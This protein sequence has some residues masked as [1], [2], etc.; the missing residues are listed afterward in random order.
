MFKLGKKKKIFRQG[1]CN[2]FLFQCCG[3]DWIMKQVVPLILGF[4]TEIWRM[5]KLQ[6]TSF[7]GFVKQVKVG[8]T[9][10]TQST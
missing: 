9:R 2:A 5:K 3:G 10:N 6:P 4:K 1:F 7:I 8:V